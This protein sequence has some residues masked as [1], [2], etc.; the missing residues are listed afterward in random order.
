MASDPPSPSSTEAFSTR[1]YENVCEQIRNSLLHN[2]LSLLI[3]VLAGLNAPSRVECE[4]IRQQYKEVYGEDP[5]H[6]LQTLGRITGTE[7]LP[8]TATSEAL[9]MALLSPYER[10]AALAREALR[11]DDFNFRALVEIFTCRKSSHVQLIQRA[12]KAKFSTRLDNDICCI[13]SPSFQKILMALS[14]SHKAHDCDVS[15]HTAKC[16]AMRLYQTGEGKSGGAI[17]EAVVL[18]ILSK[19]SVPQLKLTFSCY[20]HIYGHTYTRSLKHGRLGE[21]EDALIIT[22]KCIYSPSKYFSQV[23]HA[24]LKGKRVGKGDL[25]RIIVTRSEVDLDKIQMVFKDKYDLE[26]K[27]AICESIPPGDYREFLV[28]LVTKPS[29][30]VRYA[31]L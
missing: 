15:Q 24:C 21:F 10:D 2:Q 28:M 27:D 16:D 11:P 4:R 29:N 30:R 31:S 3:Q 18:E 8:E 14:A 9:A 26:L 6:S 7:K 17:D 20:K 19:R 5:A 1:N 22:V 23:M 25:V 12:Y 13:D